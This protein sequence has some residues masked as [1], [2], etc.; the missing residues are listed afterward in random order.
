M[1]LALS[2][3]SF[4]EINLPVEVAGKISS[5]FSPL[6]GKEPSL[7]VE[8]AWST[9]NFAGRDEEKRSLQKL[10]ITNGEI[11]SFKVLTRHD[12][13][14]SRFIV[15]TEGISFKNGHRSKV[16]FTFIKQIEMPYEI[17]DIKIL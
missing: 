10:V 1:S 9:L 13:V 6:K 15:I 16:E 4:A 8:K 2:S 3:S 7:R 5:L 11:L 12:A 17:Y 14:G